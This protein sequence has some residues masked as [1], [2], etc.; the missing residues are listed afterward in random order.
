[1]SGKCYNK[2]N[3]TTNT[4]NAITLHNIFTILSLSNDPTINPNDTQH[5][6]VQLTK[7]AEAIA[8]HKQECQQ[9]QDQCRHV[10]N[11]LQ[12][13]QESKELF[14]DESITQTQAE[15]ERTNI[16]KEDT[17]NTKRAAIDAAHKFNTTDI[18]LTQ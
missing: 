2:Y 6:N 12:R 11:T 18:G 13:C 17:S 10:R 3:A 4:T 9:Q 7:L 15:H 1:V 8:N 16:A 5:I 14:F